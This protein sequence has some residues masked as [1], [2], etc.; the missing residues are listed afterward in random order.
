M[1]S[2]FKIFAVATVL[3]G[4]VL[5]CKESFLDTP[6]QGSLAGETL[7]SSKNGVNATLV[8]AYKSLVGWTNDWSESPWGT[9]PSNWVWNVASDD[10]HKGSEPGDGD[11]TLS[12]QL[13]QWQPSNGDLRAFWKARYEGVVRSNSAIRAAKTYVGAN[14]GEKAY[15]DNVTGQALFLRAYYH[16]DLFKMFKNIPYYTEGD[17]D[18]RKTQEADPLALI[19][20]DFEAS[21]P[22][23]DA[24]RDAPGKADKMVATAYLGKAKLYKKDYAGALAAFNTV[25]NSGRFKLVNS[26][27]DNF[28]VADDNNVESIFAM[29]ASVNDGNPDGENADFGGRLALP[30][31]GS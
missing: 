1:K 24:V 31:S 4:S 17:T 12:F 9:S 16:F 21:I 10:A 6:P 29:Q 11:G 18:F 8:A 14:A 26:F 20:K 30:H 13:Y 5:A 23:L 27:Y 25:I 15:A 3:I 7:S 19:I 28:T 2:N 22:L